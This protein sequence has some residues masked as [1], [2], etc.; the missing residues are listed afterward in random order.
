[1]MMDVV[2][3]A[4][5]ERQ[6]CSGGTL[7][8]EEPLGLVDRELVDAREEHQTKG[9]LDTRTIISAPRDISVQLI[10]RKTGESR[11]VPFRTADIPRNGRRS[12]R[13]LALRE[14]RL[15]SS[16]SQKPKNRVLPKSKETLSSNCSN[17]EDWARRARWIPITSDASRSAELETIVDQIVDIL[18][19]TMTAIDQPISAPTM[20]V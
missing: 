6:Q 17:P 20:A 2:T 8:L 12:R 3:E 18:D 9:A 5:S 16:C 7:V 14:K 4:G 11:V 13:K 15:H 1:M 10:F 19:V